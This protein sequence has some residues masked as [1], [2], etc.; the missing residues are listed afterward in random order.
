MIQLGNHNFICW[1]LFC[2]CLIVFFLRNNQEQD[3]L[4]SS[5]SLMRKARWPL[6]Q[7]FCGLFWPFG[8]QGKA[9]P[10]IVLLSMCALSDKED[11]ELSQDCPKCLLSDEKFYIQFYKKQLKIYAFK[12]FEGQVLFMYSVQF[13][14]LYLSV[15]IQR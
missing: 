14:G 10:L 12:N 11:S 8:F 4:L 1:F 5:S 7:F 9:A 15:Q 13:I 2:I 3:D 6:S